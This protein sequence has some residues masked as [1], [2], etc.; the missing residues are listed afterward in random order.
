MKIV[1]L[2][3][4][5]YGSTGRISRNIGMKAE[6][7]GDEVYY[8]YGWTKKK[9]KP[10]SKNEII[11]TS[12]LSKASH[13]ALSKFTGMDG[14]YSKAATKRLIKTLEKIQP[15]VIHMHIMHDC[16]LDMN[17]L[18][19]YL[20]DSKAKVIW[21]F[22]DCWAFTGGCAYFSANGCEEWKNGCNK[23]AYLKNSLSAI[24]NSTKRSWNIKF[25]GMRSIDNLVITVPSIWLGKLVS[26]SFYSKQQIEVVYNGLDLTK[27]QPKPGYFRKSRHLE[28]KYI[29]LGVAFDWGYRKGLDVFIELAKLLPIEYQ[30]VLV[31]IRNEQRK[32]LPENIIAIAKTSNQQELIEIYSD[33]DVLANPTRE[34]NFPTVNIEALSC[35]TPIVM[36]NTGGSPEAID[37]SCGIVTENKSASDLCENIIRACTLHPFSREACVAKAKKFDEN[38][39]YERYLELYHGR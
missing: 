10:S 12:F 9:Q 30:I 39:C 13:G 29:V 6:Q 3:T 2:N 26:E 36:F 4:V 14:T 34:D 28:N 38:L 23:C 11:A 25:N 37:E 21:T 7:A 22:H 32:L 19:Q 33:A 20:A 5:P 8:V 31:G 16:F 15:D 17:I 1:I 27:F 24:S 18:Y 35:G